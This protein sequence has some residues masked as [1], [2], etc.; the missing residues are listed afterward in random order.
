M[1]IPLLDLKK[2]YLSLKKDIDKQLKS[3]F[4][5]QHWILG[6][7]VT[8]FEKA[9]VKYLGVKYA[10]GVASGTDALSLSLAALALKLKGR[11]YFDKKDEIIT[12]PFT[13]IATAEAIARSGATPVFVDICPDTFNID[14]DK[15]K[16]AVNR[17]TVGIIPVHLYGRACEMSRIREIAADDKLFVLEDTAQAFGASYKGKK[18][19]SIGDLGAFS[20]FPSK[21]L[22]CY[23]DGGLIS[24]NDCRLAEFIK[25][26]RNH[27][28]AK[29]YR[30]DYLGFNS[31]LD[32]IQAAVLLVKLKNIDRF[33]K[34]RMKAAVKYNKEFKNVKQIKVPEMPKDKNSHI[35]H[36]YTV[37][38]SKKR[39]GLL[40]HLNSKGIASRIYYP[41]P[42]YK[43]KA[44][45]KA[46][47]K[48]PFKGVEEA[49]SQALSL[50][51]HP[52]LKD[53]QIK[54]V[55]ESVS[56]FSKC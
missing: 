24:T 43:M 13:F 2:E 8:E 28:Q 53:G 45:G 40:R 39:D 42:L 51:I 18:L 21:N 48:G 9:A 37:K 55:A 30:A 36:L 15:I 11:E 35:Y 29:Q 33:N 54:Y 44:F 16:K 27:G 12:T 32:S 34:L 50:P 46:R 4:S 52:F 1:N 49:L 20:F 19:G 41:V 23:G 38:V 56:S 47:L 5:T 31:R 3:C 7:K 14:P 17:N 22:G 26:L 6:E 10:L 25:I